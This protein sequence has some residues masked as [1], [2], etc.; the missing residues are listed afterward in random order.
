MNDTAHPAPD[1]AQA[2]GAPD[3]AEVP[4]PAPDPNFLQNAFEAMGGGKNN[5]NPAPF[6]RRKIAVRLYQEHVEKH[7][8][9][10]MSSVGKDSFEIV[11]QSPNSKDE[12]KALR[13]AQNDPAAMMFNLCKQAMVSVDGAPLDTVKRDSMWEGIGPAGRQMLVG[14]FGQYLGLGDADAVGKVTSSVRLL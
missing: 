5:R 4:A 10:Y 11:L 3:D 1:E 6:E 8:A 9:K 14:F 12:L 7:L 13:Q 2:S